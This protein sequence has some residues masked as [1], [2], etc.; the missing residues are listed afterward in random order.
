MTSQPMR[1]WLVAYDVCDDVRRDRVA[2]ALARYGERVQYSVFVVDSKPAQ[3]RRLRHEVIDLIELLEDSL[4]VCDLGAI[5]TLPA[6]RF[7]VIGQP[8]PLLG[9]GPLIV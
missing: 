4:L 6:H 7:E 5:T 3:F 8:R 1:R 9:A 2:K